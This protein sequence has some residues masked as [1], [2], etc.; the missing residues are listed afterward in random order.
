M[1]GVI[2]GNIELLQQR[3]KDDEMADRLTSSAIGATLRGRDLTQRLL[4]FSR[5]Q[6]LAPRPTDLNALVGNATE[7]LKRTLEET[8]EIETVLADDLWKALADPSQIENAL[9]NLAI[10]A[11]DA[12]AAGGRLILETANVRLDGT[13]ASADQD[14]RP[15]SYVMLAVTDTGYGMKPDVAARA[16]D[17]FFTTKPVGKGSGLG[18]SM[19]YGFA[20]QSGGHVNIYS[21]E[22]LG[23]TVKLYLPRATSEHPVVEDHEPDHGL[24]VVEDKTVLVVE[25]DPDLRAV[26]VSLLDS[27]GFSI[28]EARSG[29]E[30][31]AVLEAG[32]RVD[33]LFTDVVLPDGMNGV[34][35]AGR[36]QALHPGLEVLFTS[37][38]AAQSVAH[39]SA[40][41]DGAPLL[42]K[43][44]R[45]A[46]LAHK[47][48]SVFKPSRF[49]APERLKRK[50]L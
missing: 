31:L 33:L 44:Y 15:G 24:Q 10:N 35:L 18:L 4:A 39:G 37:G 43:P 32:H 40:L 28:L 9:L 36:V 1:L 20:R 50:T 23:T 29:P 16:F 21:E 22:E 47:I 13:H 8:I 17:P 45:K 34:D 12:M 27:M 30:A 2:L 26:A 5:K 46:D 14:V 19:V 25:D 3:Y 48:E 41:E 38:Y 6:V 42:S 49:Q 11:R 7:M